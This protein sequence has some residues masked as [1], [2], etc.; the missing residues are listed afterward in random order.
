LERSLLQVFFVEN[1]IRHKSVKL[2]VL[3]VLSD[4]IFTLGVG[5]VLMSVANRRSASP[6]CFLHTNRKFEMADV[7][8]IG[9][10]F[11]VHGGCRICPHASS[12]ADSHTTDVRPVEFRCDTNQ[13]STSGRFL[14]S[15]NIGFSN[16]A[17][18]EEA[19]QAVIDGEI[20]ACV[21]DAPMLRYLAHQ[22]FG[23][24]ITVLPVRFQ[25][26]SYAFALP[27]DSR[28]R[29]TVNQCLLRVVESD[30]WSDRVARLL[31]R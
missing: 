3:V 5:S 19:M 31:G 24:S 2:G 21:Y 30:G 13:D 14:A 12:N 10:D 28:L 27:H 26:A 11:T 9:C 1:W 23:D 15:E 18:L 4:W 7:R 8:G 6:A 20:D 29:E 16:Y 17:N 25:T 22:T